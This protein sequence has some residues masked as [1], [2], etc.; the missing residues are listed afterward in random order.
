M[1][2]F[3]EWENLFQHLYEVIPVIF[4]CKLFVKPNVSV[5]QIQC[6]VLTL[7]KFLH[8]FIIVCVK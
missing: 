6:C 1:S 5:R 3:S 2:A 4:E 8:I 7:N